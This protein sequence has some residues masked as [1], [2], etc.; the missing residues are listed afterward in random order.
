[1]NWRT[2]ILK[3]EDDFIYGESYADICESIKE[4]SEKNEVNA[5][6]IIE[7]QDSSGSWLEIE[8]FSVAENTGEIEVVRA[9][10]LVVEVA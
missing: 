7:Y 10:H 4:Y 9:S 2:K 1:M 3:S 5:P 6:W 8:S